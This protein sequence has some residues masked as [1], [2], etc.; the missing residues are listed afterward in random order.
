MPGYGTLGPTEGTGLLPWSWAEERLV[1][2][3]DFWL[4]TTRPDGRPHLMPVWGVW[5]DGALWFGCAVGSRK[6]LN[7]QANPTCSAATDNAQE[8]VVI[9]GQAMPITDMDELRASLAAE[10]AKYGTQIGEEM[11]D[12][13]HNT[14]FRLAPRWAFGLVEADFQ[15]SPTRWVFE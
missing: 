1:R 3:H 13:E 12:L 2:S 15:G 9:E 10:N 14:W 4:A 7:L 5:R 8:P 11:I 6:T